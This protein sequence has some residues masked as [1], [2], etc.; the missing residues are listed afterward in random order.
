MT[1]V[2]DPTLGMEASKAEV[3]RDTTL[4]MAP[5]RLIPSKFGLERSTPTMEADV[6]AM[7]MV[8]YQVLTTPSSTH[9]RVD[10]SV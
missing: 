5:K 10:S 7:A 2:F 3:D 9:A 6:Y 4:F 8:I 1:I